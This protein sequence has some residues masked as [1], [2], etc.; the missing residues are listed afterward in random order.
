FA[1]LSKGQPRALEAG[2]CLRRSAHG[3][4]SRPAARSCA[5]ARAQAAQG[6]HFR[7]GGFKRLLEPLCARTPAPEASARVAPASLILFSDLEKYP[8]RPTEK[9]LPHGLEV[10]VA[11]LNLLGERVHVAEAPIERAGKNGVDARSLVT[12]VRNPDGGVNAVA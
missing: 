7:R 9:D 12:E 8:R 6:P 3:P 2:M 11:R 4:L 10:C 1:R 5:Q